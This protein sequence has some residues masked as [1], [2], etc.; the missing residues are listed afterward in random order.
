MESWIRIRIGIQS[1]PIHNTRNM[2]V[3]ATEPA[4]VPVQPRV[5]KVS[6]TVLSLAQV[7]ESKIRLFYGPIK[8]GSETAFIGSSPVILT[9]LSLNFTTFQ[10]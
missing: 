1:M 3:R 9:I 8:L 6:K 5:Q 7:T 4:N 10:K 2:S